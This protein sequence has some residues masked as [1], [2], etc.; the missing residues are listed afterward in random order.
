LCHRAFQH[1][2]NSPAGK[3]SL[4]DLAVPGTQ[5][6]DHEIAEDSAS[7]RAIKYVENANAVIRDFNYTRLEKLE[8]QNKALKQ[9]QTTTRKGLLAYCT[10]F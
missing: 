6:T 4:A 8:E 3:G 5:S 7:M 2:C 10:S 1:F 9:C